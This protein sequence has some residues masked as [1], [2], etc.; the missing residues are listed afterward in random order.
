MDEQLRR[1][2]EG[3]RARRPD[4]TTRLGEAIEQLV[5]ERISPLQAKFGPVAQVWQQLLP[6]ELSRHCEIV[7]ISGGRLK[8][9]V[10]SPSY[11]YELQLCSAD[12]LAELQEQCPRARLTDIKFTLG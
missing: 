10:D 11:R 4:S 7:G 8:V 9:R 12:L 2:V 5:A 1:A 6:N 3:R